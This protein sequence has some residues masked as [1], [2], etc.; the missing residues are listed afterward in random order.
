MASQTRDAS[1]KPGVQ[2]PRPSSS[3]LLLSPTNEILLL[4][5]VKTSTS[6]ASAHVFPG[7]NLDPLHDVD[8][9]DI[10]GPESA[11][12]HRD[13]PA[14]RMGAIRETFEETGILLATKNG[15]LV[16]LSAE[17]RDEARKNIHGNKVKFGDFLK[18]IG[19]VAD[20]AGLIPF[21]RWITPTNVPKRF[22]TQMYLYLL[23]ISKRSVP[24]EIL[25]PTPD[26][27]VEH[28]AAQFAPSQSWL[29][30]AADGSIILFPPQVY[31]MKI[32]TRFLTGSTSA[33]EEGP[34]HYTAQRK[35]LVS[36]LRRRVTAET[37]RGKQ[38]PTATI[39]WADK[40]ISPHHLLFR[41]EDG[42]VVLG[43]DKPGPELE[44][45]D[46]GGDWE[47]V[48]LVK[49]G[50]GGPSEVEIRMR[51]EVLAEQRAKP[52]ARL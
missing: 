15:A 5:R 6:F 38:H 39:S 22:T 27:G 40:V 4:H 44:G 43:L 47:R 37:D 2:E 36:F 17:Q 46:R 19:A 21:T 29:D 25:L 52:D 31:L 32:L 45:S 13:G 12:R 20:T 3:V 49:F 33:L 18:S 9:G 26:G 7:G 30:K 41:E 51:E 10:P 11:E 48:A 1:S 8:D 24:S 16:N 14:Y 23:P 50:R 34:L 28:T 42:R 35:K